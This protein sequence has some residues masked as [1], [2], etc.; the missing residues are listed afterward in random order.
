MGPG[1]PAPAHLLRKPPRL[2]LAHTLPVHH[3]V[4]SLV[5]GL[6]LLVCRM[7]SN[8]CLAH[9]MELVE[10]LGDEGEKVSVVWEVF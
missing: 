7:S 9:L 3:N 6:G 4:A 10:D 5:G 1:T 2:I 8:A